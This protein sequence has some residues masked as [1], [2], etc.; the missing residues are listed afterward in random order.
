MILT[1]YCPIARGELLTDPTVGAISSAK[2]KTNA[3]VS[4][5]W[6][7]QH[8]NVAA[9]PRALEVAHVKE[10]LDIFDF[11]LTPEE[12]ETIGRLRDRNIRIANPPERAPVWDIG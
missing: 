11:S 9:V 3:Q 1:A 5:R 8:P 10:N 6:V 12:M 2:G 4:L 7:I